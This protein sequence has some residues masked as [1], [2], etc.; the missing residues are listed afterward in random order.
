MPTEKTQTKQTNKTENQAKQKQTQNHGWYNAIT[1]LSVTD[2]AN[3]P[4]DHPAASGLLFVFGCLFCVGFWFLCFLVCFVSCFCRVFPFG[5]VTAHRT[6]YWSSLSSA[7]EVHICEVYD[8]FAL[9]NRIC[10]YA[11]G[12]Q[13]WWTTWRELWGV[14]RK[15]KVTRQHCE[16]RRFCKWQGWFL[17]KGAIW[18][19]ER[20]LCTTWQGHKALT[21]CTG[22]WQTGS[23][24][25]SGNSAA[26]FGMPP[27][28][29]DSGFSGHGGPAQAS[30]TVTAVDPV[31][32]QMLHQQM[33]LSQGVMDLLYRTGPV[34]IVA[35]SCPR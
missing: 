18:T 4:A 12:L 1:F 25:Q 22:T 6:L 9:I 24:G 3:W 32:A 35:V 15:K 2:V 28:F 14:G 5:I 23:S 17:E 7:F 10:Q 8:V 29:L 20:P 19:Q 11:T 21:H 16:P 26:T 33:L 13:A 31:M 30:T 34:C 27:G